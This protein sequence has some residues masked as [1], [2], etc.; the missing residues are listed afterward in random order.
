MKNKISKLPNGDFQVEE[1]TTVY[2][3]RK[4]INEERTMREKLKPIHKSESED[5]N[6]AILNDIILGAHKRIAM[7]EMLHNGMWYAT[8]RCDSTDEILR[9][10]E[11][12][13]EFKRMKQEILEWQT[14]NTIPPYSK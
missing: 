12:I 9:E 2:G 13:E 8:F 6:I 10:R 3:I 1:N 14:K 11:L 5:S 4:Y 7:Y